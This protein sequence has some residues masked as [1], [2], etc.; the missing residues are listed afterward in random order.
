CGD[1]F[2]LESSDV[3]TI[4]AFY[5]RASLI[6]LTPSQ[7]PVYAKQLANLLGKSTPGLLVT[8]DYNQLDMNGPPFA[9]SAAEVE[10]LFGNDFKISQVYTF[11]ALA[12]NTKFREKG[13]TELSEQVYQLVRR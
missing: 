1:F 13:L 8:L 3:G 4:D 2:R 12:E 5:D 10:R 11:D 7:R 6:A 9:V